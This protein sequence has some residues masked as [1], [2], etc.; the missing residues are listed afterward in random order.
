MLTVGERQ[1]DFVEKHFRMTTPLGVIRSMIMFNVS[2]LLL[3]EI[4]WLY[5]VINDLPC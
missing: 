3:F 5:L 1:T 4:M 2:G